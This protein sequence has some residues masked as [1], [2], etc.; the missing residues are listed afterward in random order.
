M[1]KLAATSLAVLLAVGQ[2]PAPAFAAGG[3]PASEKE[4]ATPIKHLVV[5][6]NE[7][8]SFDHY[9][10]TYPHAANPAGEPVFRAR[11]DT[12]AVNRLNDGLL[13]FNPNS[14]NSANNAT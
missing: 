3:Y 11:S 7:N 6:F 2:I 10:G 4:T 1:Q 13:N 12:P 14:N 9:F 5:I 8:I